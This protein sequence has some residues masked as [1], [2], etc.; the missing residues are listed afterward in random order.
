MNDTK[1]HRMNDFSYYIHIYTY[2]CVCTCRRADAAAV[3]L[4]EKLKYV[5]ACRIVSLHA[6][7]RV[8]SCCS[9]FFLSA[10]FERVGVGVRGI[11]LQVQAAFSSY[12]TT[13]SNQGTNKHVRRRGRR[14]EVCFPR[15]GAKKSNEA[16]TKIPTE[17]ESESERAKQTATRVC[18][19]HV[20]SKTAGKRKRNSKK[21]AHRK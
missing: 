16:P 4:C 19:A 18:V 11:A 7:E 10:P 1:I 17:S 21:N 13:T 15:E 12:A 6:S 5:C 2:V 14:E 9:F 3:S 8:H 20:R